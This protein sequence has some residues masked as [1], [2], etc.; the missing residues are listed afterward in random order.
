VNQA[1]LEA[2]ERTWLFVVAGPS[3]I[4][5]GPTIVGGQPPCFF[6]TR[7]EGFENQAL[8]ASVVPSFGA[9]TLADLPRGRLLAELAAGEVLKEAAAWFDPV[10]RPRLRGST[11]AIDSEQ[12]SA[13]R[14]ARSSAHCPACASYRDR[15]APVGFRWSEPLALEPAGG[16][17]RDRSPRFWSPV[18][19]IFQSLA[20]RGADQQP[21]G[22]GTLREHLTGTWRIL[23]AWR[24][25]ESLQLA[26]L[27]H[28]GYGT[29][30]F[31]VGLFSE[32][33]RREIA[34]LI[35]P[36][37]E[38]LVMLCCTVDRAHLYSS[39]ASLDALSAGLTVRNWRTG[40]LMRLDAGRAAELITLEIANLADQVHD[41]RGSPGVWMAQS[42]RWMRLIR[43]VDSDPPPIFDAGRGGI[44][45]EDEARARTSYLKV[46]SDPLGDR[47]AARRELEEVV[48][49][50]PWI[51]EP[52]IF[53]GE[54]ALRDGRSAE[55]L[56][57][58]RAGADLLA[59]WGTAWDKR[60]QWSDWVFRAATLCRAAEQALATADLGDGS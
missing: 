23:S 2:P 31:E 20:A 41:G 32:G 24:R 6:C 25:T 58:G 18:T 47:C 55:A 11:L 3:E 54:L 19:R 51:G 5:V 7:L 9:Y 28:S 37:A 14:P 38:E 50:N 48:A 53:L 44:T 56:H 12:I 27:L 4:L 13:R 45:V 21:H 35:G 60:E 8:L 33:E 36:A 57:Q 22:T 17:D 42:A 15:P 34:Q 52:H 59:A 46:I 1:A 30:I 10:C 29:D 16:R 26:G 40:E 39:L 49:L 43:S